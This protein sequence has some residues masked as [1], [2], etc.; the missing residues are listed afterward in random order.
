MSVF[1]F[2]LTVA[3]AAERLGV[4]R[5]RIQAMVSRRQLAASRVGNQWLI[6]EGAVEYYEHTSSR[7]AGRLLGEPA[8]WELIGQ[9]DQL[10]GSADDS[11]DRLRR[12]VHGRAR[13]LH[14]YVHPGLLTRFDGCADRVALREGA[15]QV[16]LSGRHA[17]QAV[18]VPVDPT[19]ADVYL[20][21]RDLR[22]FVSAFH[23]VEDFESAN[24][25]VHALREVWPFR[26]GQVFVSP[27]VA[28]LDLED[29]RDRA[30]VT[31]LERIRGG[32][33]RA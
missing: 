21:E 14:F 1:E 19:A 4:T 28:W 26:P 13:H 11:L 25:H 33:V 20:P 27:W 32:R 12:R 7:H 10:A 5:R 22:E 6:P 17:A 2:V 24:L 31:L 8:A 30:A 29:R 15:D 16:V 18:D 9:F 3:Q 23:A